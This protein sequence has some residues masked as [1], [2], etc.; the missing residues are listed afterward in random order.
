MLEKTSRGAGM[1]SKKD[2]KDHGTLG[3]INM[4]GKIKKTK[5]R[6]WNAERLTP[7]K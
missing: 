7:S 6:K 1:T 4:R 2:V 3:K 5:K